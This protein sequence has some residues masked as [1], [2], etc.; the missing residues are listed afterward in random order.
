MVFQ[1]LARGAFAAEAIRQ[2][3]ESIAGVVIY[4]DSIGYDEVRLIQNREYD[5]FPAIVVRAASAADV[6][7][8]VTFAREQGL[9]LAVKSGGHSVA[10]H[11]MIDG[12]LVVDLSGMKRV[13]VEPEVRI[14]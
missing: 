3:E 9:Q 6:A 14:A 13:V 8:S 10:S 7:R 11:S 1:E 4:P 5:R 12:A 2:F